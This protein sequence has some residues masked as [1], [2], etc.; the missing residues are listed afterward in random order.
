MSL[1]RS[2]SLVPV[3]HFATSSRS[4]AARSFSGAIRANREAST[5]GGGGPLNFFGRPRLPANKGIM[6]VP[7]QEAWV[8]IL[9]S[10]YNGR[11]LKEWESIL[12]R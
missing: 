12:L 7:Q 8:F 10:W 3:R 6:F 9:L 5:G 1:Y 11:L 2:L 4:A